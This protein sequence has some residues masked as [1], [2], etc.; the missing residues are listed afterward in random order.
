MKN[1]IV[2]VSLKI[3]TDCKTI[4]GAVNF[5]ENY[6]LPTNYISNSFKIVKVIDED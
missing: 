3:K 5:A 2:N 6:E 4:K 1:V